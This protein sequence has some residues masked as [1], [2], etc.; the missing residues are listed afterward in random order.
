MDDMIVTCVACR[1]W[2][3]GNAQA[4]LCKR[5]APRPAELPNQIAHWPETFAADMCGEGE[6]RAGPGAGLGAGLGA[7]VGAAL[8]CE[9]CRFWQLVGS[10]EGIYPQDRMGARAQWWREAGHCVRY[11]PGPSS[12]SGHHGFWRVT[13]RM[14]GCAEGSPAGAPA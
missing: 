6:R 3:S 5:R 7:G 4:G 9:A 13:H 12:T 1:F 8:A 14:D 10:K 2:A 11:A